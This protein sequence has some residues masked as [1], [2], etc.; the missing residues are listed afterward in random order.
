[1]L[2][3]GP[4]NRLPLTIRWLKQEY[5]L[6][7]KPLL[8][9]PVHMPIVHGLLISKK[10]KKVVQTGNQIKELEENSRCVVCRRRIKVQ[11]TWVV[12]ILKGAKQCLLKHDS[13]Q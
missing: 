1:M 2:R 5:K 9:P 8:Q 4:W 7:F 11:E 12:K 3:V 10:P 13:E 6:E